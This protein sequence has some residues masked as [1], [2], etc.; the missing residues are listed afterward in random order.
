MHDRRHSSKVLAVVFPITVASALG[1]AL[2]AALAG[3]TGNLNRTEGPLFTSPDQSLSDLSANLPSAVSTFDAT[4]ATRGFAPVGDRATWEKT[5]IEVN[6][7]QVE[8]NPT[9]VTAALYDK[10]M[11]RQRGDYPTTATVLEEDGNDGSQALEA[12]AGPVRTA[13]DLVVSPIRM[14]IRTPNST[15]LRPLAPASLEK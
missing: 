13:W 12:I 5:T 1:L 15:V 3:C 11:A 6:Q 7:R 2:A 10:S 8:S 4:S 14:V 9:Y